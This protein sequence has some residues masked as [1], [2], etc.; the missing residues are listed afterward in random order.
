MNLGQALTALGREAGKNFQATLQT[1]VSGTFRTAWLPDIEIRLAKDAGKEPVR[2]GLGKAA[3]R[4]LR[5]HL[6]L[7]LPGGLPAVDWAPEGRPGP[8]KWPV[9]AVPAVLLV[10]GVLALAVVGARSLLRR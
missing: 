3:A 9:V 7:D 6:H 1:G 8:S 10:V 2:E 4:I 5:P